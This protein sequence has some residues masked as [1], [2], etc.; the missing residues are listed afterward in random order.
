ML[1]MVLN[2]ST[3]NDVTSLLGLLSEADLLI[4]IFFIHVDWLLVRAKALEFLHELGDFLV[5]LNVL[6]ITALET[7]RLSDSLG[8]GSGVLGGVGNRFV[9]GEEV[10]ELPLELHRIVK[11]GGG[12]G[13]LQVE[14]EDGVE[15]ASVD[16]HLVVQSLL[17]KAVHIVILQG[18]AL[19]ATL[20]GRFVKGVH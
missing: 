9:V 18:S 1:P 12:L 16:H 17:E 8:R 19:H 4:W 3:V 11:S 7:I 6:G 13:A 20:H 5:S 10:T 2:E 15:N 14:P